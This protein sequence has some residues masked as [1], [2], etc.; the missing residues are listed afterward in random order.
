MSTQ[1]TYNQTLIRTELIAIA[2]ERGIEVNVHWNTRRLAQIV[3]QAVLDRRATRVQRSWQSRR[4]QYG[5]S[6]LRALNPL[7]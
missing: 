4:N 6:G 5:M 3:T 1:T 7:R 2:N